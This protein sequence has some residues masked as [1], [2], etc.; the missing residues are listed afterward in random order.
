MDRPTFS[1]SWSRVS[2]LT[3]TLRNHAQIHRQ[4]YRGQP[5][6][7]VH[8]P[9][10]NQFFR[11]N[12][13]AYHFVG[14][15]DGQRTVD[16]A[17]ELTLDRF[18]DSAPTQ[19]EVI[20]LL[21]QLNESN[22]L[23]V[24]LPPDAEPLLK[25]RTKR[26]WKHWG[27]QAMSILFLRFPL[28]NPNRLLDW[29][30]PL[31]RP[32]LSKWGLMVWVVWLV[33]CGWQFLP[34]SRG[35]WSDAYSVLAPSN[36]GWMAVLFVVT[37]VIHELGHGL[38]CKRFG[39]VVPE[40]G[41]MMLVLFPF[42]YVDATS[43]W[44]FPVKWQRLLVSA[45]GMIFELAIAAG[46]ALIWLHA[47]PGSLHRQLSY[48]VV[49]MAS[50]ATV[51]FNGNPLLRFDGYYMLSD[52][53]EVPNLYE[54]SQ[55][56]LKRLV[57]VYAYGM[58][59]VPPV[60][61][62][63][64]E[65]V[66][67]FTY[68]IASQIYRVL[69]LVGILLFIS[70]KFFTVGLLLGA[71]SLIA[72]LLVPLGKFIHWMVTSPALHEHRLR[73]ATVTVAF[74]VLL[75]VA[76]GGIPVPEHRR[77]VGVVESARTADIAVQT[78][79]V[80]TQVLVNEGQHVEKGEV[81]LIAVDPQLRSLYEERQAMLRQLQLALRGALAEGPVHH[82]AERAKIKAVQEEL[83]DLRSRL[84]KL[85][86]TSPQDGVLV[87]GPMHQLVGQYLPRGQVVGRVVDMDQLRVTTLVDQS[88]NDTLFNED[89]QIEEVIHLRAIG[90]LDRVVE[91]RLIKKFPSGRMDLPHPALG[92]AGGG[93]I[94]TR[95]DDE[96][97]RMMMQPHFE[98]W[99][100]LPDWVPAG[101]TRSPLTAMAGFFGEETEDITSEPLIT[102][103][104]Q[105]VYVRFTLERRRPYLAQWI[106]RLRQIFRDRVAA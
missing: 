91:S 63:A 97:G 8:D 95:P 85:K 72:W 64:F 54:R 48:N 62:R 78:S 55:R 30:L 53:L 40:V 46:A 83:A 1:S 51:L 6:H 102:Y 31:F 52:I 81:I 68:G 65:R 92:Y 3:P 103:P 104:G 35:F 71:W 32:L 86:L 45:A 9:L 99:L 74:V 23:R 106:H 42:P 58:R 98:L 90:Q 50:L 7:V 11:L 10:A 2:R 47:E 101:G 88:Q 60:T 15:L 100:T 26:R 25:R 93:E 12:P 73:A 5:W 27:G 16:Q 33:Y 44:N 38:V 69:V 24:D 4:L 87:S 89:N 29:L 34:N 94:A 22:L 80:V 41:I 96:Q 36:W 79:G 17:W 59:N 67:L 84:G 70:G 28:F 18:G 37:K 14:L 20:G 56:Q 43:S 77:A 19:N 21:G 13:V 76:F 49:F 66:V 105:R 75:I 39:G 57:Q 61:T 82:Q